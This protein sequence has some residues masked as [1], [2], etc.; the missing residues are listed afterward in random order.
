MAM[1][2]A[3]LS[4]SFSII[5]ALRRNSPKRSQSRGRRLRSFQPDLRPLIRA[6]LRHGP[7]HGL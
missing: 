2:V 7:Q 6:P 5:I 3:R 1:R 4:V